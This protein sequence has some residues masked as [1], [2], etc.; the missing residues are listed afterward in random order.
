[1]AK[2]IMG[3]AVVFNLSD[4]KRYFLTGPRVSS[5]W[6]DNK[7]DAYLFGYRNDAADAARL[8][9]GQVSDVSNRGVIAPTKKVFGR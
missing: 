7:K 3:H 4:D 8:H 9:S 1:M 2:D 5:G 6:S